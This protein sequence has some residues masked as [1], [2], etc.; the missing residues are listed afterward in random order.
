ML[1]PITKP[2]TETH[3]RILCRTWNLFNAAVSTCWCLIFVNKNPQ[4]HPSQKSICVQEMVHDSAPITIT[5]HYHP[6]EQQLVREFT[7]LSNIIFY[8]YTRRLHHNY[9]WHIEQHV[10]FI[11]PHLRIYWKKWNEHRISMFRKLANALILLQQ[12]KT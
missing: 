10:A 6:H 2:S 3:I 4:K 8:T 5:R 11:L 9:S 7:S 1:Y 12:S